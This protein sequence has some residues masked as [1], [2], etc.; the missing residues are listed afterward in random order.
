MG[1][2]LAGL[3][4]KEETHLSPSPGANEEALAVPFWGSGTCL[5]RTRRYSPET[6]AVLPHTGPSA[7][8]GTGKGRG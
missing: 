7:Q 6:E 4:K 2:V 5:C 3:E 1:K 8:L